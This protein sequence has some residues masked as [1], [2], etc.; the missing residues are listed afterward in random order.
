MRCNITPEEPLDQAPSGKTP[1]NDAIETREGSE[2]SPGSW[3]LACGAKL[4][5]SNLPETLSINCQHGNSSMLLLP[6]LITYLDT[7]LHSLCCS[8]ATP[9]TSTHKL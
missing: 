6:P 4:Y 3:L 2:C 9:S 7:F 8:N 1:P 5:A